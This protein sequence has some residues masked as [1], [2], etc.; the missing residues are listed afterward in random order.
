MHANANG[1][2]TVTRPRSTNQATRASR[3]FMT[4][5]QTDGQT[6][7]IVLLFFLIKD[8]VLGMW[9]DLPEPVI[10]SKSARSFKSNFMLCV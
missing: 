5:G 10:R 8:F 6:V 9:N 3:N 1:A 4:D 7:W 2:A